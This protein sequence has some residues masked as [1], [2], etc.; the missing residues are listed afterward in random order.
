M[1]LYLN[2][3]SHHHPAQKRSTIHTMGDRAWKLADQD[4]VEEELRLLHVQPKMGTK[5]RGGA[6]IDVI[7][8]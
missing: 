8:N 3:L 5:G 2:N 7:K 4:Y 6:S 1:N